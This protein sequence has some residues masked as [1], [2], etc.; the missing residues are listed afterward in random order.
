MEQ[1]TITAHRPPVKR[2][3]IATLVVIGAI[4]SAIGIA[5]GLAISWFPPVAS[6]QAKKIG[7]LYNVMI[8][9]TVP[10]FVLVTTVVLFSV[11]QFRMRPGEE[12]LDGPP[13][14]GNTKLEVI[15]TAIPS[16]LI[17]TMVVYA[18]IL[19]HD[20]EAKQPGEINIGVI[21]QQFAWTYVYPW[22]DSSGRR[23]VDNHELVLEI[24]KP[25]DLQ[26]SSADVIHAF[27]VPAFSIQEDAVPGI[28][29]SY[30]ITP[31]R[32]GTYPAVCTLLCGYGHALMRSSVR[33]VTPAAYRAWLVANNA[34]STALAAVSPSST[35]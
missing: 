12:R 2:T 14:H 6:T 26:L 24:N 28:T 23:M 3:T 15:W 18:A 7:D 32:L 22:K 9:L 33:V 21:G 10:I 16:M 1:T 8:I 34:S 13:I 5:I 31:N 30:R 11:Y 19:L 29:T 27:W 17:A 35:S 25:V 4:A 20:L